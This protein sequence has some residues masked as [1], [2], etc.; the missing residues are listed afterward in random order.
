M[1]I[2]FCALA[3]LCAG[4]SF[5]QQGANINDLR[6]KDALNNIRLRHQSNGM[7]RGFDASGVEKFQVNT[8]TGDVALSGTLYVGSKIQTVSGNARGTNA[9][10]LQ[11]DRSNAANIA[12]GTRSALIGGINN[13]V[14]STNAGVFAGKGNHIDS[15]TALNTVVLG[16][17]TNG[18]SP[19]TPVTNG[20]IVAGYNNGLAGD[21]AV[22]VGGYDNDVYGMDSASVGGNTGRSTGNNSAMIGCTTCTQEA[23]F[24]LMSGIGLE[25]DAYNSTWLG[26]YNDSTPTT[27]NSVTASDVLFG[28]GNGA[29][30]GARSNALTLDNDGNGWVAGTWSAKG[31]PQMMFVSTASATHTADTT[32]TELPFTGE[33]SQTIPADWLS[34]GSVIKLRAWFAFDYAA[35][36]GGTQTVVVQVGATALATLTIATDT[37]VN[38]QFL[39]I[40]A[41]IVCRATGGS[42]TLC[43]FGN[44]PYVEYDGAAAY[45]YRTALIANTIA[46]DTTINNDISLWVQNGDGGAIAECASF[47]MERI[48]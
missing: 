48:R 34:V 33:G 41:Q 11:L 37:T 20:A 19:T 46:C 22:I 6:L 21:R 45:Q 12:V 28:I 31:V 1:R 23:N 43:V 8:T 2:L 10:D 44:A 13:V 4:V 38:P 16:G 25:G 14:Q 5:G 30:D 26:R 17:E 24:S 35:A 15:T 7:L 42:G 27:L 29:N 32:L 9:V 18:V 3:L 36:I 47:T 39:E 40:D